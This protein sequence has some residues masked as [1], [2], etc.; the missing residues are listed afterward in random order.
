[1]KTIKAGNPRFYMAAMLLLICLTAYAGL[2]AGA[3][4]KP[5]EPDPHAGIHASAADHSW[6]SASGLAADTYQ[7]QL[8]EKIAF[9][10]KLQESR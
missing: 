6:A 5:P 8:D 9:L 7:G 2:S 1:M 3:A 10:E 4:V